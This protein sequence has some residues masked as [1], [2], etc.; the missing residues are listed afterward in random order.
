M[1]AASGGTTF[2]GAFHIAESQPQLH[3][4][5][6]NANFLQ[7]DEGCHDDFKKAS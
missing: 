6:M 7:L 2:N 5:F 3:V 1:T 4:V